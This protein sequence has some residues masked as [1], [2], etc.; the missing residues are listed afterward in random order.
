MTPSLI[1]VTLL[2]ASGLGLLVIRMRARRRRSLVE[3]SPRYRSFFRQRGVTEAA[4]FLALPGAAPHIVSGH[5]DRHVAR[6]CFTEDR[7][8]WRAFLK[9]EHRVTWLTRLGNALAGFG[10]MSRSLREARTLQALQRE[11]IPGPEW[12][13]SGE[14]EQGRAFL[15]VREAP[16]MELRAVL[17]AETTPSRRRR[18][19]RRLGITLA[20]LH[21]AGF[22]HPDLY[23]NHLFL[24]SVTE[25]IHVLDWQRARLRRTLSWRE[26]QRDLAALHATVADALATPEERLLCLRTYWLA[27]RPLGVSWRSAALDVEVEARRLLSRRHIREKRQPQTQP[28][29]W[30]CHD[31]QALCVSPVM[32]Q[33]CEGRMPDYLRAADETR[34]VGDSLVR[35]WPTLPGAGR[36]LLLR[37]K[38]TTSHALWSPSRRYLAGAEQRQAALL[39]RL[40]R[41]GIPA[42]QVLALGQ[43]RAPSGEQESFLLTEPLTDTCSLETWLAQRTRRRTR[44]H[45]ATQRWSVLRQTGALLRRLHEATCYLDAG[46][47]GCGLAVRQTDADWTVVLDSADNVAPQRR[48]LARRA[49]RDV[50]RLRQILRDAGCSR[51]DLCRFQTGYRQTDTGA[52]RRRRAGGVR[53]LFHPRQQPDAPRSSDW[54]SDHQPKERESLWRRLVSGVRRWRQ[55]SDWP[56]FAGADWPARIMDVAVTDRF[57]AKQ[58]RSTG[59]WLV[60]ASEDADPRRKRLAVYLKRHYELPWWQ[61]WLATLWPWFNWSPAWREWRHLEWARRRGLPVPKTVAAAEYVGPWGKLRS[62]LAIEELTGMLSLQEAIPLAALR[63][64]A[65]S[66]RHWK[67]TLA[68]ELARLTRMLHDRRCFHKDLYLCHFFIAHDD[69]RAVPGNGWRGQVHLI[70]L[71]RLAHHP[72]TWK[73]WQTKD[74]AQLLY[75]SEIIGVDARDRLAFWRAYRGAG[76]NRPGCS[77]VRRLILYR[78]RRYR[79]HNARGK[80]VPQG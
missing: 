34:T 56:R 41:H 19:A 78:W 18:I 20:R 61:G 58:G 50:R 47:A 66:F 17:R 60:Q 43:R 11:G 59:R 21:T 49:A 24:D 48:Q 6:V 35:R 7:Q 52:F 2:A 14:D 55:R 51:T 44:S 15:L 53:P 70:D 80:Q 37:R 5:P 26:R 31:G 4:H 38:Q 46:P 29:A 33:L 57:H 75:A 73:L 45:H 54:D 72:L 40:Q 10:L 8:S 23:A 27:S 42:P 13:A 71:H 28:Q 63:Q 62:F 39:L 68:V 3:I 65:A 67:R 25:T 32:Q 30:I 64:D 76:P 74:L 22:R 12:L 9:C 1:A 79:H 16:G 69:T 77:W 36:A